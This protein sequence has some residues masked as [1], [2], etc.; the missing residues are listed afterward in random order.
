MPIGS[1]S[2][3]SKDSRSRR[4]RPYDGT[5]EGLSF[6]HESINSS[7][8]FPSYIPWQ[9]LSSDVSEKLKHGSLR[10]NR[11]NRLEYT[12]ITEEGERL[13]QAN[14][15][16]KKARAAI[17]AVR[18]GTSWT[19][20]AFLLVNTALGSGLL[21]YP[22]AYN[23]AGGVY[24]ATFIQVLM[25]LLL[26]STMIVLAYCSDINQD[27]TYHDVLMSM[28]GKRAQQLSAISILLT[29]YGICITFLI[30]IGDQYD[31]LF[32]SLYGD[33]FCHYWYLNRH[34][35]VFLTA[36]IFILP[37]CFFQRLDFLRY[38]G[39]L[40][41]FVMLF[42]VFLMVY[43]YFTIDVSPENIKLVPIRAVDVFVVVP[44]FSFAYQTHEVV[45]PLYACMGNRNLKDFTKATILSMSILFFIYCVA[46]S[47]GYLSFGTT[48]PPDIMQGYNAKDPL[49]LIGIAVLV[50][51]MITT[52]PPLALCGRGALD[53]LYA[54]LTHL[55][56]DE[57]I[58][59]EKRRRFI[60]S[61]GWFF[62]T[63]LLAVFTPNIGVVIELLGCLASANV[64]IF[65]GL[66]LISVVLKD[67]PGIRQCKSFMF[68]IL[69]VVMIT[70][71]AFVF[72][73]VLIQV[74]LFDLTSEGE[75]HEILCV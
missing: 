68:L 58:Y 49:V 72:G 13:L 67:D 23:R 5:S 45:V 27:N 7:V 55:P 16:K 34:T 25:V 18:G 12:T 51:K 11:S 59:G 20:A 66:C 53:G 32:A 48:V 3:D 15:R 6:F 52:Y 75:V 36:L 62:S 19:V 24:F 10:I 39:S 74:I 1:L 44:V 73:V 70:F 41:I 29:C 9:T 33:D 17:N 38:A 4:S 50:V 21:N 35:S 8:D 57:F 46:G 22:S 43:E 42:L 63:V 64:F 69:S 65:P 14:G 71:G 26:G 54:E 31:K 60:I 56:A 30:I 61:T 47:F 28:C 2:V 37:M 40:G